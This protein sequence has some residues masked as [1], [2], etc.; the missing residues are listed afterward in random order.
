MR[1]LSRLFNIRADEWRRLSVL[2]LTIFLFLVGN[3]WAKITIMAAFLVHV[4]A[5]YVP[6]LFMAEA[7][8]IALSFAIY[9]AFADRL[10]NDRLLIGIEVVGIA[11]MAIGLGLIGLAPAAVAYPFL[12]LLQRIIAQMTSVHWGTYVNSFYDTRSA[13]RIFAFL[14]AVVRT[15]S[16]LGA[17]TLPLLNIA[18][19]AEAIIMLWGGTLL[20]VIVLVS[21]LPRFAKDARR[22]ET[23]TQPRKSYIENIRE[24]YRYV[25]SA[26]YLRSLAAMS[27][28]MMVLVKLLDIRTLGI[29]EHAFEDDQDTLANFIGA[30]SLAGNLIMLPIQVFLFSRIVARFGVGGTNLAFPTT[31][32]GASL[33][34]AL[35]PFQLSAG[36]AAHFN[37]NALDRGIRSTN[38]ELLYNAVPVRVKG[39]A[40]GFIKGVIEPFGAVF[41]GLIAALPL[42]DQQSFLLVAMAGS[43]V[44]YWL[45]ASRVSRQYPQA[46]IT[47]LEQESLSFLL[48]SAATLNM[49]DDTTLTY[50][51]N[52]LAASSDPESKLLMANILIDLAGDDA[53]STLAGLL[54]GADADFKADVL[55]LMVDARLRPDASVFLNLLHDDHADVRTNALRGLEY[56]WGT[57]SE[58]YLQGALTLVV[59][60]ALSVQVQI[61]PVLLLSG[62]MRFRDPAEEMF[63]RLLASDQPAD[64]TAGVQVLGQ[65]G[66]QAA[67]ERLF[68]C[69]ADAD[70]QPRIAAALAVAALVERDPNT[71]A[72]QVIQHVPAL[73]HDPAE[74]AQLAAIQMLGRLA[75]LDSLREL[76]PSLES[77]NPRVRDTAVDEL[78]QAGVTVIPLLTSLLTTDHTPQSKIATAVLARIDPREYTD[79]IYAVIR[80]NLAA[81]FENVNHLIALQELTEYLSFEVLISTIFDRN[82]ELLDEAFYLLEAVHGQETIE[83]ISEALQSNHQRNYA[84][85]VEALEALI[86]DDIARAFGALFVPDLEL[87]ALQPIAQ[88]MW[89]IQPITTREVVEFLLK[90]RENVWFQVI[91]AFALAEMGAE[92]AAQTGTDR[93]SSAERSPVVHHPHR[94]TASLVALDA[95]DDEPEP[96]PDALFSLDEILV[97]LRSIA[98]ADTTGELRLAVRAAY[99]VLNGEDILAVVA[100][101]GNVLSDIE[102]II[103]LKSVPWFRK[104]T[105]NQ[106]KVLAGVCR[107]EFFAE[108]AIIFSEGDPG[109]TLYVVVRGRVGIERKHRNQKSSARIKTVGIRDYFGE[110]TLFDNSQCTTMAVALEDTLTLHLSHEPLVA[111]IRQDP[112]LSLHLIQVFSQRIQETDDQ[113]ASLSPKRPKVMHKLYDK[114]QSMYDGDE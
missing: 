108:D 58:Q 3:V 80:H 4:G 17:A 29:F 106:L 57:G 46:L 86:P 101:E 66:D 53:L 34:V 31:T 98:S 13:K 47:V 93:S 48:D 99:R 100:Q 37:N 84:N 92:L 5:R 23:L 60:P 88:S 18:F 21:V 67:V 30:I 89:S 9:S 24:G 35:F 49:A 73:L 59:D 7:V 44:A 40:R 1:V 54:Q 42:L 103:F 113:V 43:A 94:H 83:L 62:Q 91:A 69:L 41:A 68:A 51:K 38:D 79:R 45:V 63:N 27:V 96:A 110:A 52:Q 28:L 76:L 112:E 6:Y 87:S 20:A 56:L 74:R 12:Y 72:G 104:M 10:A 33:L 19:A 55:D 61:L 77:A 8:V 107:E 111:L 14:A 2:G 22:A 71:Y 105:V 15:G 81:V 32:L 109:G 16:L 97:M 36:I 70:N 50:L 26:P 82:R 114:M 75:T 102:K 25:L 78:V 65:L 64:R 95:R 39:R 85:A 90:D 11:G